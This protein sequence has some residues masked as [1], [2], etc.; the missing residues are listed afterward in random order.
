MSTLTVAVPYRD[1]DIELVQSCMESLAAQEYADFRVVFVDY[2]SEA[3]NSRLTR[4]VL[5]KYGFCSYVFSDTRGYPWNK[6]HALNIA[7]RRSRSEYF[8]NLDVDIV[9]PKNFLRVAMEHAS[10]NRVLR[11]FPHYLP[12][13][14]KSPA[15]CNQSRLQAYGRKRMLGGFQCLQTSLIA[16][17]GGYD[18]FY[19]YWGKEDLDIKYRLD[20]MD[21]DEYWLNSFTTMLHQ[22]HPRVDAYSNRCYP[23]GL[24]GRMESY[25]QENRHTVQRNGNNWGKLVTTADRPV[26]AFLDFDGSVLVRQGAL[27]VVGLDPTT[28]RGIAALVRGFWNLD[29]GEAIAIENTFFP[30]QSPLLET[31]L[32]ALNWI[33]RGLGSRVDYSSNLVNDYIIELIQSHQEYIADYYLG[34]PAK[35]G[36]SLLVRK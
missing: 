3:S 19:I 21:I 4:D 6:A 8:A 17:I 18:E 16:G 26:F 7:L 29:P 27:R 14:C 1:R 31:I 13:G 12:R 2:G 11:C 15:D 5:Q 22:W 10:P 23:H 30:K 20:E 24:W 36:V 25:I 34:F 28:N 9:V 32:S 33:L 35:N